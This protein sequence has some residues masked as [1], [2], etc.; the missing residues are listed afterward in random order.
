MREVYWVEEGV[1]GGRCGPELA[2]W[3]VTELHA[4]GVRA[5]VSLD[6]FGVEPEGLRQV[7]IAHLPL[8]RPMILLE[9]EF[10]RRQFLD[11]VPP[12]LDFV[13]QMEQERRP[14]LVHCYYGRDRTGCVLACCLVARR[15]LTAD[16]AIRQVR[17]LQPEALSASGYAEAV[18]LFERIQRAP[19]R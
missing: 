8:Y 12:V 3:D 13:Q 1:L 4:A 16:E 18:E 17:T 7:D 2:P 15:G 6:R 10:D 14:V 5:I 11:I 9:T 19:T